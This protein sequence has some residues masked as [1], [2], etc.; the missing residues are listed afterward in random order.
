MRGKKELAGAPDNPR[1]AALDGLR[2]WA[3]LSVVVYHCLWQTFGTRFPE[4]HNFITSLL[5]NGIM[6]V[7]VFLTISGYVLTRKRW[8]NPDNPP[9]PVA[10]VRRYLRLT[11]PI[12]AA[13]LLVFVLMAL[14]LTPTRAAH[15]VTEVRQWYGSFLRFEPSL[16]DALSFAFA[17]AY[18]W[19]VEHNYNPFLWTMVAELWGSF[20]LFA[21]SQSNRFTREPYSPLLLL[22]VFAL[23]VFPL[24]ACFIAGALFALMERDRFLPAVPGPLLSFVASSGLVALILI[25]T[26][27]QM[28]DRDVRTLAVVGA[29]IFLAARYSL[30]AARVLTSD[31]S[32]F[33]GRI[34]YPL[35]LVQFAVI[36]SLS[37]HL[38][39]VADADGVLNA[40][41]ALLIAAASVIAS[42]V[43][44][45]LFL[46]VE[47]WTL[48]LLRRLDQ[49]RRA[50][51][52]SVAAKPA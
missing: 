45:T 24:A 35:Y 7:A 42:L 51:R 15:Q 10:F 26:L 8:R 21:L 31:V 14:N 40:T 44:A 30:P 47:V 28:L 1:F 29:G 48:A 5:G 52:A 2:G 18:T 38:I 11:I 23:W 37:A 39:V 20:A 12:L 19:P 46:P 25:G 50:P 6:A 17:W 34:S 27:T 22:L 16:T 33:L 32:Q 43:L 13:T 4:T 49:W 36:V 41:S 9:L 3:A